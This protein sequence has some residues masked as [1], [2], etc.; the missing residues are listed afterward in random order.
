MGTGIIWKSLRKDLNKMFSKRDI[1]KLTQPA[2]HC[3]YILENTHGI[4]QNIYHT[5]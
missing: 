1:N 4:V 3:T 2:G 5:K